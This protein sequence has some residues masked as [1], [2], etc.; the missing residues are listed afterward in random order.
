M[1]KGNQTIERMNL[2]GSWSMKKRL[3]RELNVTKRSSVIFA[4]C[5][6]SRKQWLRKRWSMRF[7]CR[8]V[9][10][11]RSRRFGSNVTW[12]RKCWRRESRWK[13]RYLRLTNMNLSMST[14]PSR[15]K[16]LQMVLSWL[17]LWL[18]RKRKSMRETARWA[19]VDTKEADPDGENL[20]KK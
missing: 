11:S 9:K 10:L 16:P 1:L 19:T 3:E 6:W 12:M 8:S 7:R 15:S 13:N 4:N 20:E 18:R 17:L 5:N 14:A 2:I